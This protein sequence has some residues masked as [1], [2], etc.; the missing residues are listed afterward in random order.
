MK[1]YQPGL[2][3]NGG[4][5]VLLF[6]LLQEALAMEDKVLV[7]RYGKLFSLMANLSLWYQLG[8]LRS[9]LRTSFSVCEIKGKLCSN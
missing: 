7:F 4:K 8:S 6:N 1:D 9:L 5:F 3:S 2:L